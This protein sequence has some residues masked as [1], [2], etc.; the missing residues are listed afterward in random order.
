MK[1]T[2]EIVSVLNNLI[3]TNL[4]RIKGYEKAAAETED[5]EIKEL[6]LSFAVQSK[7]FKTQLEQLVR[8]YNGTPLQNGSATAAVYRA[9][10]EVKHSITNS[11]KSVLSTCE[12]GEDVALEN[13]KHAKIDSLG[14]PA[15]VV[16]IILNQNTDIIKA[17]EKIRFFQNVLIEH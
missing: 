4:D 8:E 5:A 11:K 3:E 10:M 7:A 13:Y 15:R 16:T 12:T 17:L 2:H 1:T 6:C 14:F 9:A